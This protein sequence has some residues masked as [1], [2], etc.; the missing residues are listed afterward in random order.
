MLVLASVPVCCLVFPFACGFFTF[1]Q[2]SVM[3]VFPVVLFGPLVAAGTAA[4]SVKKGSIWMWAVVCLGLYGVVVA[5]FLL[6]PAP[7]AAWTMGFAA[8][9][10]LT[11]RPAEVQEWAT[12]VLDRYDVGGLATTTNVEYWAVGKAKIEDKEIPEHIQRMWRFKPSIG[13]ATMSPSGFIGGN[14]PPDG[15]EATPKLTHCVAFSWYLTGVLVGRPDFRSTW[16]PWYIQEIVPGVY[17]YS[18]MK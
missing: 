11:K 18:G 13:V 12:K 17:A 10:R 8:N 7:A 14:F 3:F 16:N 4:A 15:P 9:F 1:P 6:A 5:D 2:A